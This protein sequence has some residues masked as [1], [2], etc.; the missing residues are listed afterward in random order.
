MRGTGMW[1]WALIMVVCLAGAAWAWEI[2]LT[3]REPSGAAG[4]RH[5]TGG[6]PLLAGQAADISNLRLA[7]RN[8]AG[9]LTAIPAQF[10]VLARWWRT[11]RSIRWVLV[12]FTAPLRPNAASQFILTDAKLPEPAPPAKLVVEETNDAIT[13]TTGPA[14][15]TVSRKHFNLL[16]HA[17]VDAN[18]DGKFDASEDI[19]AAGPACGT[20]VEDT[21]GQ[22]YQGSAGTASVDVLESGPLRVQVR[23][24]GSH[25]A[26]EG[27]GYSAGM[28]GY[29]VFMNFYGGSADVGL[30]VVITNNPPKSAGAPTFEDASLVLKLAG[31]A[32]GYEIIGRR[33]QPPI[34]GRLEGGQSVCLYQDSNGDEKTW[35]ACPGFGKMDSPGWSY[36][37]GTVTSFCGYHVYRRGDDKARAATLPDNGGKVIGQGDRARGTFLVRTARGTLAVHPRRFWQ[38]FPKAVEVSLNGAVR[39]GLFPRECK[40]VHFLEDTSAKGHE[41]VL[42]F[43]A[44]NKAVDLAAF[45]T[46]YDGCPLPR[47]PVELA[48]ACGALADMPFTPPVVTSEDTRAD[49]RIVPEGPRMFTTDRL[50]GNAYGWQV[51][52]ERWRSNGGHGK[53]GARQPIDQD[54]YFWRW[55]VTGSPMW[56]EAGCNRSRHFRDVR[57]YRVDGPAPAEAPGVTW[58]KEIAGQ[59]AFGFKD[60]GEFRKANKNEDWTNRPQ[61]KGEEYEKYSQGRWSRSDWLFPNPEHTVLDILYDRYLLFGDVRSLENMRIAAAHGGYFSGRG[62]SK[63]KGSWQWRAL[64]WGW[65]ALYRYWELTGD[66]AA[67]ACLEDV[68]KAHAGYADTGPFVSG[69]PQ[70]INWWFTGIYCRAVAMTAAATGD[71]R[72]LKLCKALA[73]GKEEKVRKVPTLF[74][75]LYHLTGDENYK[76]LVLGD[77]EGKGLLKV[78]GYYTSCDHWL[79]HQPPK[80][81]RGQSR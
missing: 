42:R 74:A 15:F 27:K 36:P 33:D 63:L 73:K 72:M 51:F 9:K 66:K 44:G 6:V 22:T 60:W 41:I 19:L 70:K 28:Y 64:G 10:R 38:Q 69:S 11:D 17:W 61:P 81:S 57:C 62:G 25:R 8:E 14:R 1:I 18:G 40:V 52:G 30:D 76:K 21:Y 78:P 23:A 31:G 56:L 39:I 5:I 68:M 48:G 55:Y 67:E 12:D 47:P 29:D 49:T 53:R 58:P 77:D 80:I 59:D 16:E 71:P 75:A 2:P 79:L 26:P 20:V 54:N 7:V 3:V 65:R 43:S 13:I 24:R 37:K 34:A 35:D 50:Y 46:G 45:A 32:T 4:P